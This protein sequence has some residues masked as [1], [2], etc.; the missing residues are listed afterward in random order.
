MFQIRPIILCQAD[1]NAKNIIY[2]P[3]IVS[4]ELSSIKSIEFNQNKINIIMPANFLTLKGHELV[5]DALTLLKE[6]MLMFILQAVE[7]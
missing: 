4:N 7:S 2:N 3:I 6:M 1:R 5:F